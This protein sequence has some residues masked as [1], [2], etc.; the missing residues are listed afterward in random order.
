MTNNVRHKHNLTAA[1]DTS[2]FLQYSLFDIHHSKN[3]YG[4]NMQEQ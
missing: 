3:Q 4:Q 2:P 1:T